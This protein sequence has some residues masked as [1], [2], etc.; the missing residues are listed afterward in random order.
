M[1]KRQQGSRRTFFFGLGPLGLVLLI[2]A[3]LLLPTS[4]T[5]VAHARGSN[6][7]VAKLAKRL[8]THD[9]FRVRTQ[10]ALALGATANKKAVQPLCDGLKDSSTT[11]R[12]AAAAALGKLALGG[13]KCLR[14]RLK[15]EKSKSVK[16]VIKKSLKSIR[17]SGAPTITDSTKYYLAVGKT[18]DKTGRG[19]NDVVRSAISGAAKKMDGYALAPKKETAKQAKKLLKKH[20]SVLALYL[21]PKVKKPKYEGGNL[22][23]R[24][25]L[26]IFTYPGKALKGTIP[27]R[28]TQQGVDGED[29]AA[30]DEL[31]RMAVS[32]AVKKLSKNI[33]RFE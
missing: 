15:K 33:S 30:E 13:K 17:G 3:A 6:A 5:S 18:T 31:I 22:T 26:A 11:V 32:R 9:D 10:A 29:T 16:S 8:R 20:K 28:L 21:S 1:N 25:E 23:V 24:V 7:K 4:F 27:V 19:V 2:V 14:K 12:A